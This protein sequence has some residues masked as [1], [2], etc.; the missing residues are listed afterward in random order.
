M[1]IIS[2][3]AILRRATVIQLQMRKVKRIQT[4]KYLTFAKIYFHGFGM[5]AIHKH[6]CLAN[7]GM[8][9]VISC[10]PLFT[11]FSLDHH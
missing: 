7:L 8:E 11:I 2:F 1:I 5:E 10:Q 3:R 4:G 9:G 6:L